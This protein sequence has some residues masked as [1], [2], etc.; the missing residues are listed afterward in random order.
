M[1]RKK[2][3][4]EVMSERLFVSLGA[5]KRFNAYCLFLAVAKDQC[6]RV[7]FKLYSVTISFRVSLFYCNFAEITHEE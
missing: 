5:D 4:L 2:G 7:Y 1:R 3:S 6:L